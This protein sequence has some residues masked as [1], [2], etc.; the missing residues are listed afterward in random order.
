MRKEEMESFVREGHRPHPHFAL[1]AGLSRFSRVVLYRGFVWEIF[2]PS[3]PFLLLLFLNELL[4]IMIF[5]FLGGFL[6]CFLP[7]KWNTS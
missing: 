3:T 6:K 5:F 4:I 2:F 1:G 7:K